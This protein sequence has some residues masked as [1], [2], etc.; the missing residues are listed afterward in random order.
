MKR[1]LFVTSVLVVAALASE[2]GSRH[3][4]SRF[5]GLWEG[6]DPLD[7]SSQQISI[8]AGAQGSFDLLWGESYWTICEGRRGVLNGIGALHEEDRKTLVAEVTVSCFDPEEVVLETSIH[9]ELVGQ[10]LLLA[11]APG[12][13][14]DLPFYRVSGRVRGGSK[15]DD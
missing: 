6:V 7:G 5:W 15:A 4:G 2:A 11:T 1:F 13:F 9:F 3:S 8:S 14:T 10:N 12:A